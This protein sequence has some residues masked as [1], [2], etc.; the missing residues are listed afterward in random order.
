M[1]ANKAIPTAIPTRAIKWLG[2]T[3]SFI[4]VL[5]AAALP[6]MEFSGGRKS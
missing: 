5:P 3:R 4:A 6:I 2:D 1:P